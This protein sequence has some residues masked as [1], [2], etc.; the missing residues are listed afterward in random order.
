MNESAVS[1]MI[2]TLVAM[3]VLQA[4]TLSIL[5]IHKRRIELFEEDVRALW[6]RDK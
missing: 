3:A 1:A 5:R 6:E 4:L 2:L